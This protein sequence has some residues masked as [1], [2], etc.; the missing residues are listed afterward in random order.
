MRISQAA[1]SAHARRNR[2]PCP[3]RRR[4]SPRKASMTIIATFFANAGLNFVLALIVAKCLGPDDFGRYAVAMAVAIVIN[5]VL[6]E[7]LRLSATRFYSERVRTEEPGIR[8]TLETGYG[9]IT[10]ALALVV[11]VIVLAEQ[12]IGG[13]M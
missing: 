8:A 1:I 12:E 2:V 3:R 9:V 7:W 5:T 13:Q 6:L 10:L 11:V 4:A